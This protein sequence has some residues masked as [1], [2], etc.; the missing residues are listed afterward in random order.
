MKDFAIFFI[1]QGIIVSGSAKSTLA[2]TAADH[3]LLAL[4]CVL[5]AKP[6][7]VG[8]GNSS[9]VSQL[10]QDFFQRDSLL[11]T[12]QVSQHAVHDGVA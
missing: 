3:V 6:L 8:I 7:H 12:V 5:L 2:A 10:L 4:L 9:A 11:T 1:S